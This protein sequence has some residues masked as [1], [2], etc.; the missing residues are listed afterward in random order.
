M[1]ALSLWKHHISYKIQHEYLHVLLGLGV[2]S[3]W[4][5]EISLPFID[6][7]KGGCAAAQL[8]TYNSMFLE[9]TPPSLACVA[10]KWINVPSVIVKIPTIGLLLCP[11]A[12][13]SDV[14]QPGLRHTVGSPPNEPCSLLHEECFSPNLVEKPWSLNLR[15]LFES[16]PNSCSHTSDIFMNRSESPF[17]SA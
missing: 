7:G 15:L 1:S 5:A 8:C 12:C 16:V 10:V 13:S 14:R 6:K 9:V 17:N 3:L 11:V 4:A 2:V